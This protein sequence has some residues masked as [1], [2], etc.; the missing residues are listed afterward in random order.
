MQRDR[1]RPTT[2]GGMTAAVR[3][4]EELRDAVV[5]GIRREPAKVIAFQL[6]IT[7]EG[8]RRMQT[9]QSLPRPEHIAMLAQLYPNIHTTL[10]RCMNPIEDGE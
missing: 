9:G 3:I 7:D 5:E 2:V 6:R 1:A 8:A 10:L 4:R